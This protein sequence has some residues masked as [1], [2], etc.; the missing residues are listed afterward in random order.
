MLAMFK[1]VELPTDE[2]ALKLLER[3]NTLWEENSWL[4][5]E[6]LQTRHRNVSHDTLKKIV[7]VAVNSPDALEEKLDNEICLDQIISWI[8]DGENNVDIY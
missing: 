7:E 4:G 6:T 3:F 5:G 2:R 8:L 1:N